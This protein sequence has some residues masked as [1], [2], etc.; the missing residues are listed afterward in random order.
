MK[1]SL[2]IFITLCLLLPSLW[3]QENNTAKTNVI[4]ELDQSIFDVKH[5]DVKT[6][7]RRIFNRQD[8]SENKL[9]TLVA[10]L[11]ATLE[12][13]NT[14]IES[15]TLLFYLEKI[16]N[17]E[18]IY[19]MYDRLNEEILA[20]EENMSGPKKYVEVPYL[21]GLKKNLSI[22]E[23]HMSHLLEYNFVQY[24]NS[25][26][27]NQVIKGVNMEM[28]NDLFGFTNYDMNY[29]GGGRVEIT[30]DYLKMRLFPFANAEKILS[31]Q[32]V[33]LG[34]KAYTPFIRDTSIFNAPDSYDVNDRPFASYTYIGRSKYRIH[35]GGHMRM[36]SDFTL[37][38]IGGDVG[39]VIQSVIHRDQFVSSLKPYGWD[40]QIAEG[41]RFAWNIDNQLDLMLY[42]GSGDIF[43]M[44]RANASWINIPTSFDVHFGNELTAVGVGL[45]FSTLSFKERSGN[46]DIRLHNS[47][48]IRFLVNVNARYSYVIHNSMLEGIGIFETFADDD[49]PLAPTDIYRLEA[50]E[51]VRHLFI[52]DIFI[53]F[54][55]MKSTV[56]WKLTMNT[57][58]YYKPKAEDFYQWGRFGVNYLL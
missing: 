9:D 28:D 51:V 24:K 18:T 2:F 3:A 58:E 55:T 31:Y 53:G 33:S 22:V 16:R 29:T 14:S 42:S 38:V 12:L 44:N 34:F 1:I 49:D 41:G 45:G 15:D 56:Y 4:S 48:K 5:F 17:Y 10:K 8:T 36:R 7:H 13:D 47:K 20:I 43:D 52:A 11:Y 40:S 32:G 23:Q 57:K 30:T 25:N 46:E 27:S 50:N 39:N 6:L 26:T 21:G 35:S 19:E 37:G 54:R